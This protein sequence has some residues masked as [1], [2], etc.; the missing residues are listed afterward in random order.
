MDL[1]LPG[2]ATTCYVTGEAFVED[3]RVVSLLVRAE[4]DHPILRYDV[5]AAAVDSFAAPGRVACRWTQKFKPRVESENPERDLKLTAETLFLTLADPANELTEEDA[6]LV[7]FLALMME[8]KRL[9]KPKGKSADGVNTIYEHRG[10]KGRYEV[11]MGNLDPAFFIAV[12]EQLTVLVGAPDDG[13]VTKPDSAEG[14][15]SAAP[16]AE[17]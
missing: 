16:S 11:P 1:N 4:G 17:T 2:L 3:E 6:R 15:P 8:R 9:I 13:E 7:Q 12:Q 5:T 10:T 14:S